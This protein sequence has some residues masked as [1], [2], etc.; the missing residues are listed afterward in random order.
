MSVKEDTKKNAREIINDVFSNLT[1]I[2]G[3]DSETATIIQRLWCEDRLGRGE[4]LSELESSRTRE[5]EHDDEE[6]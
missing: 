3:M 6:A 4:L 1:K 2:E 5:G